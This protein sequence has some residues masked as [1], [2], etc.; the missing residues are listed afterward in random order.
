L[1]PGTYTLTETYTPEGYQ[2]LKQSVTVVIQEDGT[3]MIDGTAVK[4]VLVDGEQH[5][6]ISL[7]VT[8]QAKVPLPETG[9]SGRLG[10]Y[11]TGLIAL[12]L[13]G[14]YLFMRNH[15]KDVMK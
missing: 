2:G 13:S 14:V 11:L 5:N 10:I 4:N 7:D 8:N 1:Q 6:Q 12:G 15:G 3:V 9:G